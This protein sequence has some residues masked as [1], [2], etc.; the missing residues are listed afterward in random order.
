MQPI[1]DLKTVDPREF[2]LVICDNG[3]PKRQ[4]LRRDEKVIRADGLTG[5]FEACS[6]FAINDIG[7]RFE[8]EHV[9]SAEYDFELRGKT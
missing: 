6:Q 1:F 3:M 2:S 7:G 5:P 8:R 4:R 9:E